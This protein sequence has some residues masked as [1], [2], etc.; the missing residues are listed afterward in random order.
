[1]I[2]SKSSMKPFNQLFQGI[3]YANI[4]IDNIPKMNLYSNGSDN[5]KKQLQRMHGE[6]LTL[7]AQ[8]YFEA[9][10]NWGDLPAHFEPAYILAAGNPFPSQVDRDTL[11]NRLL[12]ELHHL[13]LAINSNCSNKKKN[14]FYYKQKQIYFTILTKIKALDFYLILNQTQ[15][16]K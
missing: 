16:C 5:E 10:R 14:S 7:R 13:A 6:A 12:S 8:F 3:E 15:F 11:Y 4:C 1:M 9:I 2:S